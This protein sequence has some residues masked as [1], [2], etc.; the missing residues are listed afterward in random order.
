MVG[1]M[2]KVASYRNAIAYWD[3]GAPSR[4][5][6]ELTHARQVLRLLKVIDRDPAE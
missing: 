1:R 5:S 2:R 6:N 3:I 4:G